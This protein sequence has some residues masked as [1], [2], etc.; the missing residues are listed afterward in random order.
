M[1]TYSSLPR[2][3]DHFNP[4]LIGDWINGLYTV[5]LCQ[6]GKYAVYQFTK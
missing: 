2:F 5:T 3:N 4:I 6:D 1:N